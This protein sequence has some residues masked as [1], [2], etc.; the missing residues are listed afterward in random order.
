MSTPLAFAPITEINLRL[1]NGDLS[2]IELINLYT[3]RI[4]RFGEISKAFISLDT[5]N[6]LSKAEIIDESVKDD[7]PLNG[8]PYACKDLF[9]V[10]G[11]PTTAGSQV[12]QDN[13]AQQDAA[14][15]KCMNQAGAICIG[16][17]N[18]LRYGAQSL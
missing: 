12:L 17:N 11:L 16:K 4:E 7:L 14:A 9:D 1:R 6:A 5:K 3:D 8:I 10:K 15:I 2:A 13:V 18:P